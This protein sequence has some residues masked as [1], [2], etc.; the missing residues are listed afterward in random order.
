MLDRIVCIKQLRAGHSGLRMLVRVRDQAIEPAALPDRVVV[1]EDEILALG[2]GCSLVARRGKAG[3]SIVPDE[4]NPLRRL[5]CCSSAIRRGI[6]DDDH[7]KVAA[8]TDLAVQT[9]EALT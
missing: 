2:D 3:G 7:L 8:T 9:L 5:H 1:E 6:V 4:P